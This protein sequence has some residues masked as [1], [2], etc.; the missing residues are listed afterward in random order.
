ML[1]RIDKD[2]KLTDWQRM[3]PATRVHEKN[4]M[5]IVNKD[6]IKFV[7]RLGQIVDKNAKVIIDKKVP[8]AI[9]RISGGSQVI[10]YGDGWL[11]CVHEANHIPGTPRRFYMHRFVWWDKN[12]T[13]RRISNPFYLHDPVIEFVAGIAFF[14]DHILLSYGRED[15]EPWIAAIH[16]NELHDMVFNEA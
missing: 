8:L 15:K 3:L 5:P 14:N 7:Y 16:T 13:V 11:A 6:E 9:D 4:W 12:W 10:P 1:A 2:F